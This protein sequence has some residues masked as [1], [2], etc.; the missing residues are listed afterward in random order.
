MIL[1]KA[2][3]ALVAGVALFYSLVVFNN[4]TDFNSNYQFVRHVLMMDSTFPANRGMWRSI[5]SP[6]VHVAF[7]LSI[8]AWEIVTMILLWWGAA[9]M[10]RARRMTADAFCSAKQFSLAALTLSLLMWLIAFLTVG[11]EW[12]LMWQSQSWNGQQAAT[13]NFAVVGLVLLFVAQPEIEP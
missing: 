4:L 8:I 10:L 6:A 13:R 7:Y 12:F 11:G 1:R 3:I 9:R 2:K 5:Q